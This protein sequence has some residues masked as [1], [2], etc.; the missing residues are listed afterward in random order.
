MVSGHG[1]KDS[2]KGGVR[3]TELDP[4]NLNWRKMADDTSRYLTTYF[5]STPV[6]R[7][8]ARRIVESAISVVEPQSFEGL[9]FAYLMGRFDE[10][11]LER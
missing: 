3:V 1:G 6:E 5:E 10:I 9:A 4:S 8:E 7:L 11:D 2:S